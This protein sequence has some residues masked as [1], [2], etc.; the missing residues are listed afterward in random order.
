VL[1]AGNPA[2]RDIREPEAS[3]GPG[4][5]SMLASTLAAAGIV[6][7]LLRRRRRAIAESAA[8]PA[9]LPASPP[10]PPDPYRIAL[11]RLAQIERE[12][13]A[14]RGAVERHYESAAD[15]LRDYLEAAEEIPARER[16]STELLWSLPPRL[17]EDGLRRLTAQVLG[18]ADLVKFARSRPDAAAAAAHLR[19]ARELLS[20]WHQAAIERPEEADAIR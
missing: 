3:P 20:R 2:L 19:E 1:P 11:A 9:A 18:D 8:G 16:T 12:R 6:W 14:E 15:T 5:L 17:M 4:L 10:P 13:W 7:Y